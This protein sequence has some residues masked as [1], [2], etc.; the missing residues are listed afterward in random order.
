MSELEQQTGE[1]KNVVDD[2]VPDAD[3]ATEISEYLTERTVS[4]QKEAESVTVGTQSHL[5]NVNNAFDDLDR[6]NKSISGISIMSNIINW[7]FCFR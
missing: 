2:I 5:D 4:V 7:D 6:I 1:L 3:E